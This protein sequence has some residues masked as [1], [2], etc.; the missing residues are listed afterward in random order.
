MAGHDF[1]MKRCIHLAELGKGNVSPNPM[2]GAVLVYNDIIIGEG[3]HAQFGFE[4]AEVACI[5]SVSDDDKN[6]IKDSVLYVSLEPC[7]HFGK[8]PPCSDFIIKS[9]I[10]KVVIAMQDPFKEVSGSGIKKLRD[11]GIEVIQN[12]LKSE[13]EELNR[14]FLCFQLNKRP[15]IIL[16]WAQTADNIIGSG[17][18]CRI[19]ISN[20]Y[21]DYLVHLWRGEE[22]AIMVGT[23]TALLDNPNLNNRSGVGKDPLRVVI[24][25]TLKIPQD[26]NL[27][28]PSQPTLIINEKKSIIDGN[29]NFVLVKKNED[30][31]TSA[32]SH[33]Y[34]LNIN[35]VIVE[36]GTELLNSF[37]K[38]GLWD[39]ARIITNTTLF[40]GSGKPSPLFKG[41]KIKSIIIDSDR[42]DFFRKN[43]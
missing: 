12:V 35:S 1:Y 41:N 15:F 10:K 4:H 33:L 30:V 27:Y 20:A 42:I 3:F 8:T 40:A 9:K 17:N 36:G 38:N 28:N 31:L 43:E 2:V 13:A 34:S 25:K 32:L 5:N 26:F 7:S 16:K 39:E 24:D 6:L 18:E 37:I 23:N 22:D 14:R 11:N 21:S 29:I 19:K